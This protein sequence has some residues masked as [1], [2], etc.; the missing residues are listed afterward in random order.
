MNGDPNLKIFPRNLTARAA[1]VVRG[2]PAISRPEASVGNTIPGLE[3]DE[4]NLD[5]Y[6]FPGFVFEFQRAASPDSSGLNSTVEFGRPLLREVVNG[7]PGSSTGM[8]AADVDYI[9]LPK[10]SL[11]HLWGVRG[12][13]ARVFEFY[14]DF[15]DD[16]G[17][18]LGCWRAIRDLPQGT[19]KVLLATVAVRRNAATFAAAV[20]SWENTTQNTVE[21][22]SGAFQWAVLTGESI[23]IIEDDG[24]I[25][26]AIPE[27]ALQSTMCTPWH[28]DFRDCKC[29]YWAANRPDVAASDDRSEEFLKFMRRDRS[30]PTVHS[31]DH[32]EWLAVNRM[33][34]V[35]V[36]DTW[37]SLPVILNDKEV[38]YLGGTIR[39]AFHRLA[40]VEHALLVE[41][42][43]AQYTLDVTKG[44]RV[45]AAA[46]DLLSIA[47]DEMRHFRW[48]NE[49]L[50]ILGEKPE[51]DRAADYGSSFEFRK[52]ELAPFTEDK[53]EWFLQVE[54]PSQSLN[55]PGQIDGM[56]VRLYAMID[57]NRAGF[58]DP[59]NLLRLIKLI[60]D[61]GETHYQHFMTIRRNLASFASFTDFL[62][63]RSPNP[64]SQAEETWLKTSDTFYATLLS[65][66]L[67][68]FSLRD[69]ADGRDLQK[70][71]RS[72]HSMDSFNRQLAMTGH[73]P[74]FTLPISPL[75][76]AADPKSALE[77][78]EHE[79]KER[80]QEI[81][82]LHSRVPHTQIAPQLMNSAKVC[83]VAH[84]EALEELRRAMSGHR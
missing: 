7:G 8:T 21:R 6:F 18:E 75:K 9:N 38:S 56:Y 13:G 46:A 36:I 33:N 61:E 40:T 70:S 22:K 19:V 84:H 28:Y 39:Q 35:E 53:L 27:G 37:E 42:L 26:N 81:D 63:R 11:I 1:H 14:K 24:V 34:H 41:Y 45:Q 30:A 78:C 76:A 48:V 64:P 23:N 17:V 83:L 55:M 47:I 4:R 54:K 51:L 44:S 79:L 10:D 16:R 62:Q 74:R 5:S 69:R 71:V 20:T 50:N 59:D 66:L 15:F 31:T 57:H 80:E 25:N 72:M 73:F 68:T 12:P 2:N 29:Y 43:F 58:P 52:F 3:F 77:H 67:A 82:A 60:I 65:L 32:E 49:I